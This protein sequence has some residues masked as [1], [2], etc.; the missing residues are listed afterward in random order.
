MI[1]VI[2]GIIVLLDANVNWGTHK[3]MTRSFTTVS[4]K[5]SFDDFLCEFR[6]V[7]WIRDNSWPESF[8]TKDF[9]RTQIHADVIKFNDVGMVLDFFSYI[10]YRNFIKK[11]KVQ[12]PKE[13]NWNNN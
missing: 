2:T 10:K 13:V 5:G 3:H 9:W 6:K 8:F 11:N 12:K 1:L 7:E 4:K